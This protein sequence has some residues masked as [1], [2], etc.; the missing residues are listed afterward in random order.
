ME[1][2]DTTTNP[3]PHAIIVALRLQGHVIPTVHLATK[4]ASKGFTITFVNTEAT[5]HEIIKSKQ[6]NVRSH[7]QQNDNIFASAQNSGLD[8][9][10][11]MVND[12][13]PIEF[14]R[15]TNH[16]EFHEGQLNVLPN[17]VDELVGELVRDDPS[18]CCLIVD[19][20]NTWTSQ[21]AKKYK[22]VSVSFWT[23]P[24]L[25]LTLYYYMDLLKINGH[26]A[27]QD[28]RKDTIDYIP[29]VKAIEP[30]DLI[31]FLQETDTSTV[32]HRF[33]YKAFDD[34]KNVDFV[35]C[36][37][38]QELEVET[39]L[40]FQNRQPIYAIGPLFPSG[41]TKSIVP[42]SLRTEFDC[43]QW[44]NSKH[45]G[46]VLYISFG[47]F[48]LCSKNDIEEIAMGLLLSEVN[49]IWAMRPNIVR[50]D[51]DYTLPVRFL[52]EMKGRGLIVTWT[53]Q[54]EVISH[55]S[56]GGFLT[57]CGW[58][59]ILESIWCGVP[60]LCFPLFTDQPTNRK[61]VV[62]DWRIGLNL[63]DGK[64]LNR[65]EVAEKI[66]RIM[67]GKSAEELRKEIIKFRQ[68]LENALSVNGSLERNL[69]QF[70]TDVKAKISE[71]M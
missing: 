10:Y 67:S 27:S 25:V 17:Y 45:H 13:F 68:I 63:C 7:D 54:I 35:L 64:S 23:Q 46:S 53:N 18:L 59:S 47:T 1:M 12:G 24:A 37:T 9:R 65:V 40:A 21:I 4:L 31:S 5:H 8:I 70:I 48:A 41:F 22:L 66:G 11:R 51:E 20:F 3:K 44:L 39:I 33:L 14:D 50:Y 26:F 61:L 60:L 2:K 52:D 32:L 19:T 49:F 58:N 62:D 57:H 29:G 28:N 69:C 15:F 55:P 56:I 36:N 43:T 6:R 38:V 30:K 71:R 34:V 16:E 42:T